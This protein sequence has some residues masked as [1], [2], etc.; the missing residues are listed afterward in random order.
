[1]DVHVRTAK[2][3]RRDWGN[4]PEENGS[5]RVVEGEQKLLVESESDQESDTSSIQ[6]AYVASTPAM[7][8]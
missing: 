1:M 5:I 2:A 3:W 8:L 6:R 4:K 7:E